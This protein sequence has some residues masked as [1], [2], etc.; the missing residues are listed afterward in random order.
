MSEY[1]VRST[2]GSDGNTGLTFAQGWST[3]AYA[4]TNSSS[5]DI[6]YICSTEVSPFSL[7]SGLSISSPR[8]CYGCNLTDGSQYNGTGKAYIIAN[9]SIG[10]SVGLVTTTTNNNTLWQDFSFNA[11]STVPYVFDLNTDSHVYNYEFRNCE[12]KNGSLGGVYLSAADTLN[13]R[14]YGVSFFNCSM[15][16][17]LWGIAIQ[18]LSGY[19]IP[20]LLNNCSVYDNYHNI[21]I[22]SPVTLNVVNSRIFRASS[23]GI[24]CSSTYSYLSMY[25]SVVALNGGYGVRLGATSFVAAEIFNCIIAH[26]GT[27]GISKPSPAALWASASH[28]CFYDNTSGNLDSNVN[29]GV[30]PGYGNVTT[31]PLFE[32]IVSGSEDFSLQST[33]PCLNAG[34]GYE[35]G[36]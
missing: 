32:S 25:G 13:V 34:Y 1:Y 30:L 11:N 8:E 23:Y 18:S 26:N 5:G 28:N 6:L 20:V 22:T 10:G 27:Y 16:G 21:N 33:S 35:G 19:R 12:F 2:G 15:H 7:T 17:N 36:K 31:D 3:L 29:S 14:H 9:Y 4:I 24:Y